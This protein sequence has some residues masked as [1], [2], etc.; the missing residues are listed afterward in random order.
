MSS[1]QPGPG[2]FVTPPTT[3]PGGFVAPPT[4]G[5]N[6]T[7]PGFPP[8]FDPAL[9]PHDDKGAELKATVWVLF[10]LATIFFALRIY[11]RI[12]KNRWLLYE[13]W[14]LLLSYICL[15]FNAIMVQVQTGL[16]YG[17]HFYDIPIENSNTMA[18]YGLITITVAVMGQVWSKTSFA[19]TLLHITGPKAKVF[20][21]FLIITINVF[22][23]LGAIFFW[24]Q[25]TPFSKAWTP[26]MAGGQCW[27]TKI[28]ISY[29]IFAS[30]YSGLADVA[31][32]LVPWQVIMGLN[33]KMQEKLGVALAMSMGGFAGAAAFVKAS[34][35]PTLAP[36]D[37]VY[38][39]KGLVTWGAAE[40]AV[41]IMAASIPVLRVLFRDMASS[42][43]YVKG[44]GG[45]GG[46]GSGSGV[47]SSVASKGQHG[48]LGNHA[49]V[50]AS[51]ATG[52]HGGNNDFGFPAGQYQ[53]Y[54]P[55]AADPR[56]GRDVEAIADSY[57][58]MWQDGPERKVYVR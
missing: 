29:G 42:C 13:D 26:L 17:K 36:V 15:F 51:P 46:S 53:H 55:H 45:K 33:L 38:E 44:A 16:G 1:G 30:V 20:V 31:L 21:W 25:C 2:G 14:V 48:A 24:V 23:T 58:M 34:Y 6:T 27:D 11:C 35:L 40:T 49:F 57:E 39:G 7:W 41:T 47:S 54:P 3:G 28:N 9:L 56:R 37:F 22:M 19:M 10:A 5:G 18:L 12:L 8:G 4:A 32:A 52:A 43:G 50:Q